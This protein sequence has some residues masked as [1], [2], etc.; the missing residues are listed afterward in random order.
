MADAQMDM[1]PPVN[2]VAHSADA[3]EHGRTLRG[4]TLECLQLTAGEFDGTIDEVWLDHFQIIRDRANQ[5]MIKQGASWSG[6]IVLSIPL[7]SSDPGFLMGR[8]LPPGATLLS[9]GN[10]LPELR[11][12][13]NM[14]ILSLA[15]DRSWFAARAEESGYGAIAERIWRQDTFAVLEQHRNSLGHLF[16]TIFAETKLRPSILVHGSSRGAIEETILDT[17]FCALQNWDT[18]GFMG[19][20]AHKRLAD[21]ARH[22]AL[23]DPSD[24][25]NLAD[26]CNRLAISRTHLQNCFQ[27]SY[28]ITATEMLRA[29]RLHGVRQDLRNTVGDTKASIGDIAA[30]WG[31]WHWSRFTADYREHFGE[32]PS[33]TRKI[34]NI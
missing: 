34:A 27:R 13:K 16:M 29:V 21:Q 10:D 7:C 28:G 3:I 20:T 6:S 31:F 11:T 22:M 5:A 1:P 8:K 33:L 19:E 32:L 2:A 23:L 30:K 26:I 18:V 25:P 12:P 24:A 15:I 4:W 14:D 9:A 17:L